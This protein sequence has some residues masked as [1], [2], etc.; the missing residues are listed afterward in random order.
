MAWTNHDKCKPSFKSKHEMRKP[1]TKTWNVQNIG[2]N[3]ISIWKH[4]NNK[5][6]LWCKIIPKMNVE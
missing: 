4:E 3:K 2:S 1:K 6:R 5:T